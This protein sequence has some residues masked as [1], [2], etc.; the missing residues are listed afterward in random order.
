M[1]LQLSFCPDLEIPH[2]F[3]E[4]YQVIQLA[5]SDAFLNNMMIYLAIFL[6]G[7][8]PFAGI[9][10]TYSKIVSCSGAV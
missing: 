7:S 6:L 9:L 1:V 4:L 5:S 3:C 8:D 10:Y 2:F